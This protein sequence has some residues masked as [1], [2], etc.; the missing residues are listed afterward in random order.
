MSKVGRHC[1][2]WHIQRIQ[3][4]FNEPPETII[5]EMFQEGMPI[6]VMAGA[7]DISYGE[8]HEWIKELGLS[9]EPIPRANHCHTQERLRR[10]WGHDP[11]ALICSDRAC[12]LTYQEIREKYGV[13]TGFI[14]DC[15]RRGA[16]WL[17]YGAMLQYQVHRPERVSEAG[18]LA[19]SENARQ[20]N[21]EMKAR[22]K[23]W[24]M[25]MKLCFR[26]RDE[27]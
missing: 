27:R 17:L 13:S 8:M 24:F 2:A 12:D 6:P 23:G 20:H 19:R 14:A 22:N 5:H 9:R 25:D 21:A 10:E 7:L 4:E 16:P 1:R 3:A 15:L 26:R 18:R 11:M